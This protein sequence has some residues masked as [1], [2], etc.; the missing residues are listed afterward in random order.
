MSV[1]AL[2][3]ATNQEQKSKTLA[4][5]L[6]SMDLKNQLAAALP[7]H[8]TADRMSRVALTELR[9]NPKL[10]QCETKSF[11]A[12]LMVCA[13]L[14]LEPGNALGHAYL[15]PYGTE[16]QLIIGYRGMLDIARRSG[17][18]VSISARTVHEN[19]TFS[20]EFGLHEELKHVPASG[21]RGNMTHVY[22]VA[23]LKD[24]GIQFDVLSRLEVDKMKSQS[25]A[26]RN[27]PWVTHY[28]EMAKKT[29]IRRLFKYLPISVEMQRA[30]NVDEGADAGIKASDFIDGE[31]SEVEDD[32]ALPSPDE[33]AEN[34]GSV[35]V[36]P[37]VSDMEQA[38]AK[39]EAK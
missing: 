15:I 38:E 10:G 22:A 1:S 32:T 3:A 35:V 36:D 31:F 24:G 18:I 7:K 23:R 21:E 27:G 37:F 33:E 6:M 14:G 11:L 34:T 26:S 8:L 13:Q 30:V 5:T 29:A 19:D 17:Q 28:D 2:K 9:K 25:K 4:K 20:Y 16:A 12:S 39:L